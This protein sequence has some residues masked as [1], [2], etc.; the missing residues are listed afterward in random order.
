VLD[1]ARGHVNARKALLETQRQL[2]VD[3]VK[4]EKA[5]GGGWSELPKETSE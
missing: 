4:L 3:L 1:A 5:L 2:L